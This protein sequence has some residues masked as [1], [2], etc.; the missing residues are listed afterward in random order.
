M[1]GLIIK[2]KWADL[3]LDGFKTVEVRGSNT[4]IRGKIGIIKSGSKQ[5]YGTANLFDCIEMDELTFNS[6]YRKCHRLD[7]SYDELLKIY[8]RPY[9]WCLKDVKKFDSPIPY[10]HK[11]GCVIWVN[12]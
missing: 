4:K 2:P 9:A 11:L 6:V 12:I 5:V 3:I 10:E 1:K 7:I 8:P